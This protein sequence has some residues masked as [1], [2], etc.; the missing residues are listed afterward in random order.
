MNINDKKFKDLVRLLE[1]NDGVDKLYKRLAEL[2]IAGKFNND[3]YKELLELIKDMKD[4][5]Y[6]I[7]SRYPLEDQDMNMFVDFIRDINKID[8]D[9]DLNFYK[10]TSS[11]KVKRFLEHAF[12]MVMLNPT[13]SNEE[14]LQSDLYVT[15]N[16]VKYDYMNALD[17]LEEDGEYY[18]ISKLKQEVDHL[19]EARYY[20]LLKEDRFLLIR[21]ILESNITYD[22]LIDFIKNEENVLVKN[23]LIKLK[24]RII[25]IVKNLEDSFLRNP[26]NPS[27]SGYYQDKIVEFFED[28][29]QF[30][31]NCNEYYKDCIQNLLN[32]V[33]ERNKRKYFNDIDRFNDVMIALKLKVFTSL[34]AFED[35][36]YDIGANKV[37][38]EMLAKTKIDKDLIDSSINLKSEL[39]LAKSLRKKNNIF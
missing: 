19:K 15:L 39:S 35:D 25:G 1:I 2:E 6:D 28:N 34:V 4:H 9:D 33:V 16:G 8:A 26:L 21:F 36:V 12:E 24:Y 7:L 18:Q 37:I 17:L 30:F 10:N 3:E 38:A 29:P 27:R 32:C 13:Y 20:D 23:E 5:G 11:I 14:L 31:Y 22:Y